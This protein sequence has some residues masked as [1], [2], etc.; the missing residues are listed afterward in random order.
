MIHTMLSPG[1][2]VMVGGGMAFMADRPLNYVGMGMVA[3]GLM[4]M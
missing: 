3:Y 2:M 4:K 1:M